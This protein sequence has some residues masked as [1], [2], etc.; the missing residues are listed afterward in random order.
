MCCCCKNRRPVAIFMSLLSPLI[1]G[2]GIT[3]AVFAC[4]FRLKPNVFNAVYDEPA[5][6][7]YIVKFT[8]ITFAVLLCAGLLAAGVGVMGLLLT[9]FK[10]K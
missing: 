6:R 2:M 9:C 1:L 7:D 10:S 3:V 5:E 4:I 8:T